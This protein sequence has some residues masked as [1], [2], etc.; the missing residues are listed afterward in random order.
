LLLR[1]IIPF[2]E[3][4]RLT[5]RGTPPYGTVRPDLIADRYKVER[6]IGRGGMAT[7]YLCK[8]LKEGGMVAVKVLRPELGSAVVVERFLREIE[9]ASELD[10]PQIPKVLDSGLVGELPYYVMTYIEG[11][12]LRAKLDRE[13]QLPLEEAIRIIKEV[14]R[15][16]AF[17][18]ARGIVH[19]DIKPP[20][21]LLAKDGIYVLDFGVARAIMASAD[22]SLTSTGVAVGTPA[23][24]SPEQALADHNVDA[25]SDIYSLGCVAYEM[26]AGIPPFVGATPQSVMAR[27]FIAPPPPLHELR[28]LIPPEIEYAVMKSLTKSPADR[29]Q[30]I[31]DFG[32]ALSMDPTSPSI[33]TQAVVLEKKKKWYGWAI[34]GTAL[35]AL[36]GTFGII[37]YSNRDNVARGR[38]A[39]ERWDLADAQ[40][41]FAKA[42]SR[43]EDDPAANL[44]MGQALMLKGAPIT[45]WS[46]LVLRARDAKARLAADDRARA[47]AL[48]AFVDSRNPHRCDPL[49]QLVAKP[50]PTKPQD[51]ISIV[52][53]GDCLSGDRRVIPDPASPSGYSFASSFQEAADL[54][55]GVIARN[56]GSGPAYQLLI[57][58]LSEVLWT[59]KNRGRRGILVG[60]GEKNF[61]A[62]P[63]LIADTIAYVPY[64]MLGT[65]APLKVEPARLDRVIAS[66]LEKLQSFA[67]SWV[68]ADPGD[69][70]AQETLA[71]ILEA[72]GLL[73]GSQ[74]SA[75]ASFRAARQAIEHTSSQPD[76]YFRKLRLASGN[77]RVLLKVGRFSSAAAL[78]DTALGWNAVV[79]QDDSINGATREILSGLLALTGQLRRVIAVDRES[80]GEYQV[81]LSSGEVRKLNADIDA[82]RQRLEDY[83]S[84]GLPRDS[85]TT[86]TDRISKNL[87]SLVR[88]SE[89]KDFRS[90][91][92]R[93]PLSLAVSVT[94][95]RPLA[96]LGESSDLFS[97]A[98]SALDRGDRRAAL[99]I[100]DSLESF[101][102][103]SAP[104]EITMDVV[105][106]EG[107]LRAALGDS[108]RA[109]RYL[110]RALGGL[111]R[112]PQNLVNEATIPAALVRVMLLR[113]DLADAAGDVTVAQ[114]WR[115]AARSLW[116]HGDPE[117]RQA[118]EG[119]RAAK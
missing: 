44:W 69:P 51:F 92:L 99:R 16:T 72:R 96:S 37:A 42:I 7:V 57:P 6:E 105:L 61:A 5:A 23:Y 41:A 93:R 94:G 81:R 79:A 70:S 104:G 66:N 84:F 115:A 85:I 64:P 54:Y 111:S 71:V 14:I 3:E 63:E 1:N 12:S 29:W 65:G 40:S 8:D 36:A 80:V 108:A 113:A 21:I 9:F 101:R 68:R 106:Q 24:M 15:P 91:I 19:R 46:P 32:Q 20:N 109:A 56:S 98:V 49:R 39:L 34:A 31:E 110:D 11:E 26:I 17:A 33:R 100:A 25:R 87:E 43:A 60:D 88:A 102:A 13:K 116:G 52:A 30:K 75:I 90:A 18:H 27:R 97:N 45:E 2:R 58:R 82:D 95:P 53:L 62:M 77:I 59:T 76:F 103:G 10:H 48:A 73:E 114:R 86:I 47:D 119:N 28:D 38:V 78:A 107:W 4:N 22:D 55:S 67:T 112:A 74:S 35:A 117:A 118:V 50:D 89:V 83:A